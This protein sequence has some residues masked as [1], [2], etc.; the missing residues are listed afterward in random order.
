LPDG[1]ES[2]TE[3]AL[4][5]IIC[6]NGK[7]FEV[8]GEQENESKGFR[9]IARD[10]SIKIKPLSDFKKWL[11]E[12]QEGTTLVGYGAD[13][14]DFPLISHTVQ[15]NLDELGLKTYDL[16]EGISESTAKYYDSHSRRYTIQEL[17]AINS[18]QQDVI[19]ALYYLGKPLRLIAEWKGGLSG[20]KAVIK[21]LIADAVYIARLMREIDRKE[22]LR[23]KDEETGKKVRIDFTNPL[24]KDSS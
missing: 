5:A 7:T 12:L 17:A 4:T 1:W 18:V 16:M 13:K 8:F 19:S 11:D 24:T 23:I 15:F 21:T 10:K 3:F 6:Y 2:P 20:Q 9:F 22:S 14:F